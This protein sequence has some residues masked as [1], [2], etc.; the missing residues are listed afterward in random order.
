MT[1]L[2]PLDR[3]SARA[4]RHGC[5]PESRRVSLAGMLFRLEGPNSGPTEAAAAGGFV[6]D[7]PPPGLARGKYPTSPLA[8]LILGSALILGTCLY[9]FLRLRKSRG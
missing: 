4:R 2:A 9:F 8:I 3:Q 1:G 5:R 7:R 6:V